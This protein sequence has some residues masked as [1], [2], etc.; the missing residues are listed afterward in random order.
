MLLLWRLL[1]NIQTDKKVKVT[2]K[3]SHL[4][5]FYIAPGG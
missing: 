1:I 4:L 2:K 3:T 5:S